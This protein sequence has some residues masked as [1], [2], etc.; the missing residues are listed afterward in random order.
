MVHL[1]KI[2]WPLYQPCGCPLHSKRTQPLDEDA[3][4]SINEMM[5][6]VL[7]YLTPE[8]ENRGKNL[9]QGLCVPKGNPPWRGLWWLAFPTC[10]FKAMSAL[11]LD[12]IEDIRE[13]LAKRKKRVKFKN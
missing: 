6:K 5:K 2:F 9:H 7:D 1:Y 3:R 4:L 10:R 13:E 12:I 11:K 8:V